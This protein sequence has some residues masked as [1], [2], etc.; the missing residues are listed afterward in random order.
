MK[1]NRT[2]LRLS[3]SIALLSAVVTSCKKGDQGKDYSYFVSKEFVIEYNKGYINNLIDI[4]SGSV[5][6]IT[7]VKQFVTSD[8]NVYKLIYKTTINNSKINASGLICVPATP[9]DYPVLSFQ[10]GTNTVNAF[11]PSEAP[12]DYTYQMVEIL[13]SMGYIVV[14]ADYPG[15]GESVQVPH[16]YLVA[17][18]TV[19]SL[20]DMLYTV[21]EIVGSEFPGITLRNEYYLLGYSLGGWATLALHK[22]I[23]LDYSSDFNLIGSSCGAGPYDILQLLEGI[24]DKPTYSMP[25]YLAYIVHSYVAYN[26]LT[27]PVSDIFNEPYASRVNT[28]FSGLLTSDQI[29]NQLTTSIAGLVNPDFISGFMTSPKYSSVRDALKNNSIA[30]WHTLIPV[31]LIHGGKDTQVNPVST[32]SMYSAMI[33]SGTSPDICKMVIVPNVDHGDGVLP[34]MIQGILFLKN[35]NSSK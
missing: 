33:Q 4:V 1:I 32:E 9:G 23:E 22:T 19:R 2:I 28:L 27:N 3:V 18:P 24:I 13:A 29:N 7:N 11:A 31:L 20:V 16:P 26:Q 21:K 12:L 17:K 6:E 14:I 15:F 34:C 35:L 30:A 8:I 25:V 10:N 5:P